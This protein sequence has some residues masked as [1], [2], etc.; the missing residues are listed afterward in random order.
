MNNALWR[1]LSALLP[2]SERL[3]VEQRFPIVAAKLRLGMGSYVRDCGK[4]R[5]LSHLVS[6][7]VWDGM[8]FYCDQVLSGRVVVQ[9]LAETERVLA[10]EH[11]R[12]YWP[13]HIVIIPKRHM[14]SLAAVEPADLPVVH[15]MLTMAAELC[16][17]V[18]NEHGGCRLSSNSGTYQSTNHL[19]FYIHYGPRLRDE[20]GR[21]ITPVPAEGG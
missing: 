21:V 4:E 14:V 19:H 7:M 5:F 10:F 12:P 20:D 9:R 18:T 1:C 3:A 6:G 13:V 8:D 16:E 15:E 2:S 11:T 17:R